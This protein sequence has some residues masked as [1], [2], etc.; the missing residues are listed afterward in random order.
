MERRAKID[1]DSDLKN[2]TEKEMGRERRRC[3]I[4]GNK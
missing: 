4:K 1:H 3:S 2:K